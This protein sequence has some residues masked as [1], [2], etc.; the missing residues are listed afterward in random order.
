MSDIWKTCEIPKSR[1]EYL[2][3]L[4]RVDNK[5]KTVYSEIYKHLEGL[6]LIKPSPIESLS[7]LFS[8]Y[9]EINSETD[10]LLLNLYIYINAIRVNH[11]NCNLQTSQINKIIELLQII[12]EQRRSLGIVSYEGFFDAYNDLKDKTP[13]LYNP[14][15]ALY[16]KRITKAILNGLMCMTMACNFVSKYLEQY[17]ILESADISIKGNSDFYY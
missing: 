15:L 1:K 5:T 12:S 4:K 3:A 9:D 13:E 8:S 10:R 2:N 11:L 16:E 17:D 6:N 7:I 14:Y